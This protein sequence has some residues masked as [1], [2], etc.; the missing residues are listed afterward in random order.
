MPPAWRRRRW[1]GCLAPGLTLAAALRRG[2][3]GAVAVDR[4]AVA[5]PAARL[6][7]SG[8]VAGAVDLRAAVE[9]PDV[10]A[11]E[12]VLGTRVT[13]T[14]RLEAHAHGALARPTVSADV[15][16]SALAGTP[17]TVARLTAHA[18]IA[19]APDAPDAWH[20][21]TRGRAEDVRAPGA[22]N[23]PAVAWTA[24]LQADPA[25]IRIAAAELDA[26]L[27][28]VRLDGDY[29]PAEQAVAARL[30]VAAADLRALPTGIAGLRGAA[31]S[32]STWPVC[33]PM[34][35]MPMPPW[36]STGWPPASP[37]PM[38]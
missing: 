13:G 29:R 16:G 36:R 31:R 4:L 12:P 30:S 22:P 11:L 26:G 35:S 18:D 1:R 33:C 3:D 23:L 25:L 2:A 5:V 7:V 15:T 14:L 24:D 37:S 9:L 28:T 38:R 32:I 17:G 19:P 6:D 27:A 8:R 20:V 21:V 10:A 34:A